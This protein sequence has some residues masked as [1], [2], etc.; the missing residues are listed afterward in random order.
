MKTSLKNG[1]IIFAITIS[2]ITVYAAS[3]SDIVAR[4]AA[5][6]NAA[7][8]SGGTFRQ[9]DSSEGGVAT[10][11]NS[12]TGKTFAI[13]TSYNCPGSGVQITDISDPANI[14]AIDDITDDASTYLCSAAGVATWTNS[15]NGRNYAIVA[16]K[17]QNTDLTGAI[18]ILDI[19]NPSD[20]VALD[21]EKDESN[22]FTE[23]DAAR[24]V[25]TWTNST[26]GRNYAIVASTTDDG[27]QII[28]ITN[29]S[30]IVAKDSFD[31][32]EGGAAD[33]VYA[34]N[35]ARDVKIYSVSGRTYAAVAASIFPD[36]GIQILDVS[37]P[38]NIV[39]KD[40]ITD[41]GIR[42]I[43]NLDL[44]TIG[45]N[46]YAIVASSLDDRVQIIDITNPADISLKDDI[47]D[48]G[49]LVLDAPRGI[50][51]FTVNDTPYAIVTSQVNDGVQILDVSD[52]TNIV[53][54]D[55]ETDNNNDFTVLDNSV[56]VET[57]SIGTTSYAIVISLGEGGVQMIELGTSTS[58]SSS[59][60]SSSNGSNNKHLTRPTFGISHETYRP[61]VTEGF[62]FNGQTFDITDNW[63]TDFERQS[64][65]IGQN[66]TF[67][68]KVYAPKDL[69]I[70]E[71]LFGIP[72][73]GKA[74]DAE[75]GVEVYYD[76]QGNVDGA[77]IIQK[78]DVVDAESFS[79][80][81]Y[82]S[83]CMPSDSNERCVTTEI[84]L[85]FLEP[86]QYDVMAIKAI[87][88]DGRTQIT[89]LNEGFDISGDSL[90]P[91]KTIS[92]AG[93]VKYEG[94][95]TVTQNAKYFK[96]WTAEDGRVFERNDYGTFTLLPQ[97]F[98]RHLDSG[99]PLTRMHSEYSA[100]I[101][102]EKTKAH[103]I[104][105][106]LYPDYFD[107][108]YD[109]INDIVLWTEVDTTRNIDYDEMKRQEVIAQKIMDKIM[110]KD[111]L[112][113]YNYE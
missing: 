37:D 102:I 105:K 17:V 92:I 10:W 91:M 28:D 62:S 29:P 86:L 90:N 100:L 8:G 113:R 64:I 7:D 13:S 84:T 11:T 53:A 54:T 66:N 55:S 39:A 33:S 95:I 107:E 68:A 74:Q 94:M 45:S 103:Y 87:D 60:E 76:Y 23:L 19:T 110:L 12:T 101:Q 85:R 6:N 104:M 58:S 77:K 65:I 30:D 61:V 48:D 27:V 24:G 78:T 9:L 38:T 63:H 112:E 79:G 70:Q 47:V 26:T 4:D 40:S 96:Y 81:S 111:I 20:V 36:Y 22:G 35:G 88:W 106:K 43:Y 59:S 25:T 97:E 49:S 99:E 32:L 3:P 51:V 44:Y 42:S 57:F 89:Y 72:E 71:F 5:I 2:F 50:S 21:K 15:T 56:G 73:V 31:N 98:A 18:Q 52:P 108:P 34:L 83:K 109:K 16:G 80:I 93:N 41:N 14:L 1:I 46:H 75:L 82:P 67:A 69:R